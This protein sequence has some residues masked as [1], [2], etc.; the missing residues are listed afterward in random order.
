MLERTNVLFHSF[1]LYISCWFDCI[2]FISK[3]IIYFWP[4]SISFSLAL[5]FSPLFLSHSHTLEMIFSSNLLPIWLLLFYSTRMFYFIFVF[6]VRCFIF[7]Q[8]FIIQF[9]HLQRIMNVCSSSLSIHRINII[10]VF[11]DLLFFRVVHFVSFGLFAIFFITKNTKFNV[12]L[13]R[14]NS[15]HVKSFGIVN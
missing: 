15:I 2:C 14:I 12:Y 13:K 4:V 1:T 8:Y 11:F 5:S 3:F 7:A 10:I 6:F 9:Q